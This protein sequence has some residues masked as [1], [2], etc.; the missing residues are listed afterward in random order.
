MVPVYASINSEVCSSFPTSS[1]VLLSTDLGTIAIPVDLRWNLKAVLLL[2][3]DRISHRSGSNNYV[4]LD[5]QQAPRRSY[6]PYAPSTWVL[7]I[8][9]TWFVYLFVCLVLFWGL[10]LGPCAW[11]ASTVFTEP[12]SQP[13]QHSF[14]FAISWWLRML[15]TLKLMAVCSSCEL[16]LQLIV[17]FP[18][19]HFWVLVFNFVALSCFRY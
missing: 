12:P 9:H 15:T 17:P 1:L 13:L 3:W 6:C 8:W 14:S 2:F 18:D 16:S 5:G 11:V 4:R 7:S 10:N 19:W